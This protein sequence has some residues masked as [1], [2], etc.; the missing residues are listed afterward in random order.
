LL[1]DGARDAGARILR[2]ASGDAVVTDHRIGKRENLPGIGRIGK[3]FFVAGHAGIK[4]RLAQSGTF[5][6][7]TV[8]VESASVGQKERGARG[9]HVGA[10]HY[11]APDRKPR[12]PRSSRR[13]AAG[14]SVPQTACT[15]LW[16]RSAPARLATGDRQRS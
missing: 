8:T 4:H 13:S 2:C 6:S 14:A 12:R 10:T 16:R 1:D 5:E 7:K 11:W 9:R 3:G 15:F